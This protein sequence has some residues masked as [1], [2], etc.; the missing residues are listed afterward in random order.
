[1]GRSA[2]GEARD[3]AMQAVEEQGGVEFWGG[4]SVRNPSDTLP[5]PG[6]RK[7]LSGFAEMSHGLPNVF[8]EHAK[9]VVWSCACWKL[10]Y[11]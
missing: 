11:M 8:E 3:Q 6:R 7:Q 1:M 10:V 2:R 9:P 4:L 5:E